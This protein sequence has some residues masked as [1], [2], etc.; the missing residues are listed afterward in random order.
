GWYQQRESGLFVS[1]RRSEPP[2]T[3]EELRNL[4]GRID[5]TYTCVPP[6]SGE[7]IGIDRDGD[8]YFDGDEIDAGSDP[9]D[10]SSPTAASCS[11]DCDGSGEVTVDEV[12]KM[13]NIAIGRMDPLVCAHNMPSESA[14][15]VTFCVKAVANALGSCS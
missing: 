15:D 1:D 14:V 7:R 11:G 10:P 5:L 9:A 13:V 4:P 8:G 2:L 3:D 12:L 6:G